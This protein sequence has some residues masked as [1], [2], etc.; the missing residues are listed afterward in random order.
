M[1]TVIIVVRPLKSMCVP[2]FTLIG[3]CVSE[4]HGHLFAHCNVWSV[5]VVLQELHCLSNCLHVFM[6]RVRG[7]YHV[8]KFR[9]ST[10]SGFGDS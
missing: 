9:Y 3:C 6:I 8:T 4:L 7:C 2:S 1:F 5:I 10:L